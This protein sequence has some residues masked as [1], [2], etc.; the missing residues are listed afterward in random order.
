[1]LATQTVELA[2]GLFVELTEIATLALTLQAVYMHDIWVNYE[3]VAPQLEEAGWEYGLFEINKRPVA[4]WIKSS[5]PS[6]VPHPERTTVAVRSD[7]SSDVYQVEVTPSW[8]VAH[9][10]SCKAGQTGRPCKHR[11]R[12]LAKETYLQA[13]AEM[14]ERGVFEDTAAVHA[15]FRALSKQTC[16]NVAIALIIEEAFGASHSLASLP[17]LPA[18]PFRKLAKWR[19]Q[20]QINKALV[21]IAA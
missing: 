17:E 11:Y 19:A 14:V 7:S 10:C 5:E 2:N 9:S 12:A 6:G 20:S 13:Q 18:G 3:E 1:M 16:A 8:G 4:G 15:H 21:D